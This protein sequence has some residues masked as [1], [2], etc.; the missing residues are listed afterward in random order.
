MLVTVL[1]AGAAGL[2]QATIGQPIDI[3]RS[4]K[5]VHGSSFSVSEL[6]REVYA[7]GGLRG[8]YRGYTMSLLRLM[9]F[10]AVLF[11]AL[12]VYKQLAGL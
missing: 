7:K 3:L 12:R 8:F 2:A 10:N 1:S 4:R 6:A 9:S 5:L 11:C